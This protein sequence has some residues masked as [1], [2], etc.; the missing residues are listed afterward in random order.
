MVGRC[1]G[2]VYSLVFLTGLIFIASRRRSP[3][4]GYGLFADITIARGQ[5]LGIYTGQEVEIDQENIKAGHV[6]YRVDENG[7]YAG[8]RLGSSPLKWL[9]HSS[10]PNVAMRWETWEFYA[11]R[12]IKAGEEIL[13]HYGADWSSD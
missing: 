10:R 8:A 5:S 12:R 2:S 1:P 9:N 3:I 4:H 7:E 11:T 6:L 13:L